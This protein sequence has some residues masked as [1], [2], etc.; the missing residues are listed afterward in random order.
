MDIKYNVWERILSTLQH[1]VLLLALLVSLIPIV[2][3][4]HIRPA[5]PHHIE[6]R[7]VRLGDCSSILRVYC[8][9]LPYSTTNC[10]YQLIISMAEC[11][12]YQK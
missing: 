6:L 8:Y 7:R 2:S 5:N 9:W 11:L 12:L 3:P 1:L 4:V 10:L